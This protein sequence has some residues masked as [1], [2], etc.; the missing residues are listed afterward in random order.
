MFRKLVIAAAVAAALVLTPAILNAAS[1]PRVGGS[2]NK[3]GIS[4]TYKSVKYTCK[5]IGKKVVWAVAPQPAPR[6][7]F[8]AFPN[9]SGVSV[10]S[11]KYKSFS[12]YP[13]SFGFPKSPWSLPSSG[14][15]RGLMVFVEF[16]DAKGTDNPAA[17]GPK[18]TKNFEKFYEL[19]SYGKL[20]ITTDIHPTYLKIEKNSSAYGMNKW[21]SGDPA[22]YWTD[23]IRAAS[24]I[25]DISNYNFV[26]VMP[27]NNIK[28]II[29][30]PAFPGYSPSGFGA[31]KQGFG[32]AVGGADQRDKGDS[33]GWIWLSHEMG[34]VFG[35]EHQYG[36]YPQPVWDLMDNVYIETAPELFGWHRFMQGWLAD[37][38]VIC[39]EPGDKGTEYKIHLDALALQNSK[40]KLALIKLSDKKLI[41]LELRL[42]T[43]FDKLPAQAEGVLPY[44]ITPT[45]QSNQRGLDPL[46]KQGIVG[47]QGQLYGT[48]KAGESI[49][50]QGYV[51][52]VVNSDSSGANLIVTKN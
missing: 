28:E 4:Q 15:L 35:F 37:Q 2:C 20:S 16:Q 13:T 14:N 8:T 1:T 47:P 24:K 46:N 26:V 11:C 12:E 17:V 52:R 30:G 44:L 18:F 50:T 33:T 43:G 34:H 49:T 48:L 36:F 25:Y 7:T 10:D 23:G 32:G 39:L 21:S 29:Y 42:K 38:Q 9:P 5:K 31:L 22:T 3:P 6:A 27:P 40:V 45:A 19:Q 51:I 41:G